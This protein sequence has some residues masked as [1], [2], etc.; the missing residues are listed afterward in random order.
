MC[1][2]GG[3]LLLYLFGPGGG[4]VH[5]GIIATSKTLDLQFSFRFLFMEIILGQSIITGNACL[6]IEIG[7]VHKG[8][9]HLEFTIVTHK[10]PI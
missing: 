1:V 2:W 7:V 8:L 4:G 9:P 10:L 3:D 5:G 6:D